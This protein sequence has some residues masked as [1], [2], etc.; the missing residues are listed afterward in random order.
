MQKTKLKIHKKNQ[1]LKVKIDDLD[2]L[3]CGKKLAIQNHDNEQFKFA[4]YMQNKTYDYIDSWQ[5]QFKR[6]LLDDTIETYGRNNWSSVNFEQIV[7]PWTQ[8]D[9]YENNDVMQLMIF[10]ENIN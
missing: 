4:F 2:F 8:M 10:N 7:D 9:F 3:L 1:D 6:D 5:N